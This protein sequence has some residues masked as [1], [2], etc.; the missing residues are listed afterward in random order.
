MKNSAKLALLFCLVGGG[1]MTTVASAAE[2][3][4][5]VPTVTR[6][7]QLFSGLEQALDGATQQGDVL[8]KLLAEDFEMRV[9]SM[10]GNPIPRAQW[11]SQIGKRAGLPAD[12][13]QMAVH[14]YDS[15][16]VVSFLLKQDKPQKSSGDIYIVDVWKKSG[17]NW[18]LAVRY[19][20]PAGSEHF[21]I[22]GAALDRP[23]LD[24]R[25]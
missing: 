4:I 23:Y 22:P 11:L 21:V 1:A 6:L 16:A 15:V 10:P 2:Q 5:A 24:K 13:Q 14:D 8:D 9:G 25:Y 19:A 3:K 17:S 12:I 7:V 18:K 20:S